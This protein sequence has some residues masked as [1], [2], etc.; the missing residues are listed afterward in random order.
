MGGCHHV[1]V[2]ETERLVDHTVFPMPQAT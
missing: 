2:A 1:E